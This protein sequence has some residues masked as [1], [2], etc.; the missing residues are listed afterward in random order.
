M[1]YKVHFQYTFYSGVK[2]Q[3]CL[4]IAAPGMKLAACFILL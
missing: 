4:D 1:H 3:D 2:L